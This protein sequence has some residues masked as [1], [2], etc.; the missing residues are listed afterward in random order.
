MAGL[1]PVNAFID[2]SRLHAAGKIVSASGITV[3]DLYD[4]IERMRSKHRL[5]PMALDI[6][7]HDEDGINWP[8]MSFG[9]LLKVRHDDPIFGSQARA[10]GISQLP[11]PP[12]DWRIWD[13]IDGKQQGNAYILLNGT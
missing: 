6:A 11:P 9:C 10:N 3:G 4:A 7:N 8:N 1:D 2:V 5:C 13:Y 12:P